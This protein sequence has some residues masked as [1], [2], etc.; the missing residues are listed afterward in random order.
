MCWLDR[1]THT[2]THTFLLIMCTYDM[3]LSLNLPDG[4]DKVR[5]DEEA[6]SVTW[7]PLAVSAC[8]RWGKMELIA[9]GWLMLHEVGESFS[10]NVTLSRTWTQTTLATSHCIIVII[11]IVVIVFLHVVCWPITG[12]DWHRISVYETQHVVF[13]AHPLSGNWLNGCNSIC[14]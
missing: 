3:G 9:S 8:S 5:R 7:T 13:I 4:W 6:R 12:S 1:I 2:H 14:I 10:S 11:I